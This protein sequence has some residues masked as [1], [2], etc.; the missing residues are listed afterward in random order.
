MAWSSM[1][2]PTWTR[3]LGVCVVSFAGMLVVWTFRSLGK[4]TTDT[5][6]TRK[7][8]TLV[9][10]GPHRYVRHPFYEAIALGL[11]GVSVVTANWL[12][13]LPIGCTGDLGAVPTKI[14]ADKLVI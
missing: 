6:V 9:D 12:V 1:A 3:W 10:A 11:L 5:V 7:E 13:L 14:Q 4:N 8:H 2:I